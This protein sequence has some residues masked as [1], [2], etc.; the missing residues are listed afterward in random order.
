MNVVLSVRPKEDSKLY[1]W[2]FEKDC[3]KIS[4]LWLRDWLVHWTNYEV[5]VSR[6][7]GYPDRD[8]GYQ[9]SELVVRRMSLIYVKRIRYFFIIFD[10][11]LNYFVWNCLKFC[12]SKCLVYETGIRSIWFSVVTF[13]KGEKEV[14]FLEVYI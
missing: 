11:Y 12:I 2:V 1:N 4:I 8:P 9:N 14:F 7:L 5:P 3:R 13:L 6:R 10:E